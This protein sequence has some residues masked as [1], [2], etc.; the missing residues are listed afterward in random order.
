MTETTIGS[1]IEST[2]RSPMGTD[3]SDSS[4]VERAQQVSDDVRDKAGELTDDVKSQTRRVVSRTRE[5]L[6]KEASS[7]TEQFSGT[8]HG[9]ADELRT[10]ADADTDGKLAGMASGA[11]E[12]ADR[13][14]SRLDERGFDGMVDDLKATVR[15]RP[16]VVLAIAAASGFVV[17]RLLRDANEVQSNGRSRSNGRRRP[18]RAEEPS[19]DI[20]LRMGSDENTLA[21]PSV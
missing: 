13:F 21:G 20:D 2:Q 8:L 7:R 11:A 14:A 15:R 10:M 12:R 19:S 4:L 3:Q 1:G 5:E 9:L 18:L 16:G 6:S 17:G